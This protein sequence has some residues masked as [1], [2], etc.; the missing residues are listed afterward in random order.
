MSNTPQNNSLFGKITD[1]NNQEVT[2]YPDGTQTTLKDFQIKLDNNQEISVTVERL[3]DDT[4]FPFSIGD[5]VVVN[6]EILPTGDPTY[7]I[8]DQVRTPAL[9]MI[10]LSFVVLVISV[11]KWHGVRSL[12]GLA[13]SFAVIFLFILPYIQQGFDPVSVTIV[14]SIFIMLITFYLSHGFSPKTT[15]SVMGTF[16]SLIITGVLAATFVNL[17]KL[18]GLGTEETAFLQYSQDANFNPQGLLLSGIII[19]TLGVLDDIT[20]SQT[21]IVQELIRT[22]PRLSTRKIFIKAMNVGKDHIASLVNTLILV[23]TGSSLPLLLLFLNT[24]MSYLHIINFEMIS[25]E[26]V[27]TLVG[28]IGLVLAVPITTF[29]AVHAKEYLKKDKSPAIHQH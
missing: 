7:Y 27:R 6:E 19:G 5:Q 12:L 3:V 16:I 28:S 10:F 8:A 17:A 25:E 26:I 23:Y 4:S 24:K 14:G 22:N 18:T 1:L 21:S 20:L 11:A 15:I 29:I 13:S 2:T 9:G